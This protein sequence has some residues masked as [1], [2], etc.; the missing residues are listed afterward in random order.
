MTDSPNTT[1]TRGAIYVRSAQSNP[2]S[3]ADQERRCRQYAAERLPGCIVADDRVFQDSGAS[4]L[5]V[6]RPGL[7]AL[8]KKVADTPKS[9]SHL[10]IAAPDRLGRSLPMVFP[11]L[12]LLHHRG[13]E[14]HFAGAPL[15]FSYVHL[16]NSVIALFESKAS[17]GLNPA[18]T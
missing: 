4:G 7:E 14:V 13:I 16:R 17:D 11:I 6:S 10:I 1:P 2:A 12:D 3:L 15:E 9:F 8:L 18:A 5:A